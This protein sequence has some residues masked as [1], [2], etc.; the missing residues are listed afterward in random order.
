ME[1]RWW[2]YVL[3]F[4]TSQT[5]VVFSLASDVIT[6]AD[7]RAADTLQAEVGRL[8]FFDKILSGNR[9]IS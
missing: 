2:P 6:D 4:L 7:F 5:I 9:N 8:L 1:S 3:F